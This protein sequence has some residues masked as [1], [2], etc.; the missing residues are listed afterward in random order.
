M[1]VMRYGTMDVWLHAFLKL[2]H[3]LE[4]I[5]C[6]SRLFTTWEI[7]TGGYWVGTKERCQ[8]PNV[9][10]AWSYTSIP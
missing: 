2:G 6:A 1:A 4:V 7:A 5:S 3:R 9:T 10:N 8:G